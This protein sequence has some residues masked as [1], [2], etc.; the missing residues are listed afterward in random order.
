VA[1]H[2]RDT[3]LLKVRSRL[4]CDLKGPSRSIAKRLRILETLRCWRSLT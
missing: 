3:A 4:L 2:F 1:V